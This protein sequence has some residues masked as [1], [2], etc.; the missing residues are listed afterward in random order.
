VIISFN[1]ATTNG[2]GIPLPSGNVNFYEVDETDGTQQFVGVATIDH[3]SLNQ[4]VNLRIGTA[5]DIVAETVIVNNL[6]IGR[7]TEVSYQINLTNNKSETVVVEVIHIIRGNNV[8]ILNPSI[9][10]TRRDASIFVFNVT[11]TAEGTQSFTFTE[12]N[13]W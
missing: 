12:R 11:L 2:L 3:T 10:F 1:N 13:F 5:F 7:A 9:P 6:S 4:D 8:E